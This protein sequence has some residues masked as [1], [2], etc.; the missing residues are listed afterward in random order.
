[1]ILRSLVLTLALALPGATSQPARDLPPT[2]ACAR[3]TG[4]ISVDGALDDAA[5]KSAAWTEDFVDIVG[6]SGKPPPPLRTRAKLTWDDENLY[7]AAELAEPRIAATIRERDEQLYR[8]QAF[9]V[10]VDPGGD[11][12]HYLELQVNPLNTVCDLSMDKPYRE[13]GK[14]DVR[15]NLAGLGSAV[16]VNGSVN[17]PTDVDVDWTVELA[18]PWAALKSL[19]ADT[20]APP[21]EGE[22]WRVNFARMRAAE[23]AKGDDVKRAKAIWV[24]AAQ[25][26]VNMHLPERWGWVEFS[27]TTPAKP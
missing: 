25:G 13:K 19:S 24:W 2:Y 14:A 16:R 9:E 3:A 20:V 1:M 5:W 21:R 23:P 4:A 18:I 6:S 26:A 15:F 12:K 27:A 10:F 11:G 8:E 7:I 17:E 22:R